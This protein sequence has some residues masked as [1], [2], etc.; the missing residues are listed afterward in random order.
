MQLRTELTAAENYERPSARASELRKSLA[1]TPIVA[2]S[3]PLPAAFA[4]TLGRLLP[5]SGT[6]GVAVLLTVV[7]EMV[8]LPANFR[9][10][11]AVLR[12]H[13]RDA[14]KY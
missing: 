9:G 13:A 12:H 10:T 5:F 3:D 2:T 14:L 8:N 4:L 11:R 6:E 7:I 1:N